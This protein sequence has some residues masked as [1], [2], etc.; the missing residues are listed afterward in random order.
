MINGY[1]IRQSISDYNAVVIKK[2]YTGD[3]Y[4][5]FIFINMDGLFHLVNLSVSCEVD[6]I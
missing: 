3:C 2:Y 1:T 6:I 5:S 4:L